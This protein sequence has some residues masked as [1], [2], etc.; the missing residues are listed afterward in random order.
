M[1][2]SFII[3][4]SLLLSLYFL[5]AR[6]SSIIHDEHGVIKSNQ[7][8]YMIESRINATMRMHPC[9]SS[10]NMEFKLVIVPDLSVFDT[11][12]S[13]TIKEIAVDITKK[14]VGNRHKHGVL[15]I[16]VQSRYSIFTFNSIV[17]NIL[18]TTLN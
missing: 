5:S 18:Y 12:N 4:S 2:T 15:L 14:I 1:H 6:A 8:R 11:N 13:K 3:V 16:D 9:V 10:K 17:N 7:M